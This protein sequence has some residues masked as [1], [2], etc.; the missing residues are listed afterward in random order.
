MLFLSL[1]LQLQVRVPSQHTLSLFG[2]SDETMSLFRKTKSQATQKLANQITAIISDTIIESVIE[3]VL[4]NVCCHDGPSSVLPVC[5]KDI[6]DAC[7]FQRTAKEIHNIQNWNMQELRIYAASSMLTAEAEL[8]GPGD[9]PG[10]LR[11]ESVEFLTK[12]AEIITKE[13][14]FYHNIAQYLRIGDHVVGGELSSFP[15]K[16]ATITEVLGNDHIVVKIM[17]TPAPVIH[18]LE[19]NEPIIWV[20]LQHEE[21]NHMEMSSIGCAEA[22][23]AMRAHAE[24]A[25]KK[26]KCPDDGCGKMFATQKNLRDHRNNTQRVKCQ[27]CG[28][29]LS[30]QVLKRHMRK[31]HLN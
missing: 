23:E 22:A 19:A 17:T 24:P 25:T 21:N 26:F 3:N 31:I 14:A 13:R 4:E 11:P 2:E 8:P 1:P 28:K 27:I 18:R 6:A 20:A 5:T 10:S 15:G 16:L 30:K 12:T 9:R 7:K 29:D